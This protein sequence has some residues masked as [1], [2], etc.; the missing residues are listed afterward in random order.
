MAAP[1]Q[2]VGDID[3]AS[4]GTPEFLTSRDVTAFSTFILPK[5]G[6]SGTMFLSDGVGTDFPIPSAGITVPLPPQSI[7]LDA[8]S[9]S[10]GVNWL[11][12]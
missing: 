9:S 10:D 4:A 5:T 6:N 2:A 7:S 11:A 3:I 8:A 1:A 12:I